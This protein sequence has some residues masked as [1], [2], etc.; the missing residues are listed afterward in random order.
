MPDTFIYRLAVEDESQSL[1]YRAMGGDDEGDNRYWD[2]FMVIIRPLMCIF[3]YGQ[4]R[5]IF[6]LI[7]VVLIWYIVVKSKEHLPWYFSLAFMVGL[8]LINMHVNFLGLMLNMIFLV[9]FCF[10]AF[11]LRY[12][13]DEMPLTR[14]FYI[15][16]VNG[17]LTTFLDRYTASLLSLE[18]PLLIIVLINIHKKGELSLKNNFYTIICAVIGWGAGFSVFWFN[19]WILA[20]VFLNRN[21]LESAL[22]QA[23]GRAMTNASEMLGYEVENTGGDSSR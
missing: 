19:K 16:L 11:I 4:I 5:F 1:I 15:F 18:M 10:M 13:S 23:H 17:I 14:I 9:T 8:V 12:Y 2:G 22:H 7:D 20:S 21:I 3:S 6:T